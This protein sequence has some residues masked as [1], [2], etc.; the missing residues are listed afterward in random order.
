MKYQGMTQNQAATV[1]QRA[2][3]ARKPKPVV[4]GYQRVGGYYGRFAG[5]NAEK[6]FFDT[7]LAFSM[8]AT[9]EVP[10]TGQLNL[11]PQGVGES[12]RIGRKALVKSIQIRGEAIYL[13]GADTV[14][15]VTGYIY[16]VV[17]TQCNGA[18]ASV[19]NVLT[20]TNL[21]VALSNVENSQRFKILKRI[22]FTLH[23]QA[24]VSGAYSRAA[25]PIE[26]YKKCNIPI[27]FDAD[28][29]VISEIRSNN[30]FLIA[31]TDG[32][33]DDTVDFAGTCRLRYTDQ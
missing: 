33:V 24:G 31:G 17:D 23:S 16:V 6:K 30:I 10:A 22:Q 26:F 1:I 18:A 11:I 3:R 29:G 4:K 21:K 13:P 12:A 32:Q 7:S 27:N 14:G 8:D 15:C 25:Q 20:S 28:T 2:F 9:G 19:T 5:R